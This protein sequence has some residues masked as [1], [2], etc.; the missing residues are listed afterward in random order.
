MSDGMTDMYR[1]NREWEEE[2]ERWKINR[3]N[4]P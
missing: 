4:K 1:A 3:K 2:I